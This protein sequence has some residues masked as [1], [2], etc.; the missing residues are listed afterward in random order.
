MVF[1][2]KIVTSLLVTIYQALYA[3]QAA[4]LLGFQNSKRIR[5][6]SYN[7]EML[8]KQKSILRHCRKNIVI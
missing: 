1:E 4:M 7:G 8:A 6:V 3:L 5:F 2:I